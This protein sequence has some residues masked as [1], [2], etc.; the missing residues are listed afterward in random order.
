MLAEFQ[1]VTS[2]ARYA[3]VAAADGAD[4]A[5][6][7][8][9]VA[10]MRAGVAYRAVTESAVRLFGKAGSAWEQDLQLYYRRAWSAERL[11]GGPQAQPAA[12]SDGS[13]RVADQV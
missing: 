10:A 1:A 12:V 6:T 3:A 11:A 4:Q 13:P 8:A 9:H 7:V 2:A 5:P